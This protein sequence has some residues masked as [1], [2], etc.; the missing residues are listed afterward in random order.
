MRVATKVTFG[1]GLLLG[2]L[3]AVLVYHTSLVG[4]MASTG[5][6][7]ASAQFRVATLAIEQSRTAA[8]LEESLKKYA[9]TA[10]PAYAERARELGAAFD[11]RLEELGALSLSHREEKE[12]MALRRLWK[13]G[14]RTDSGAAV[15]WAPRPGSPDDDIVAAARLD[16]LSR[17]R[18]QAQAVLEAARTSIT[19][20]VEGSLRRS[21]R[22]ERIAR[23]VMA[24]AVGLAVIAVVITVRSI[25][26]PLRRLTEGTRAVAQGQFWYQLDETRGDEF[27]ELARDF[28]TMVRRLDELDRMKEGFLAHVSH[29]LRTPLV[30]I[31]ETTTLLLE[32]ETG[33]LNEQQRRLLELDRDSAQRLAAMIANLL[34]A[35]RMEHGAAFL[36]VSSH[37]LS[38][39]VRQSVAQLEA[40]ASE[41]NV[42][43]DAL[44]PPAA[45]I[46]RCD[47]DRMLQVVSNL[48]ENAI[49][50]SPP[51]STIRVR[52]EVEPPE[53]RASGAGS[54]HAEEPADEGR[55]VILAVADVGPGVLDVH[56]ERVF[57]KF[58]RIP[59]GRYLQGR[60]LGLGL[61]ICREIVEAHG[62]R[63]W[64]E[65]NPGGGS[66]FSLYIP[67]DG[68][69][70]LPQTCD[71]GT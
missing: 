38:L 58:Y 36:D 63:I 45:A 55:E 71:E 64:V 61:A 27:S 30:T 7:L 66:V 3:L 24:M 46:I 13:E 32:E 69:T 62:G 33:P 60:G 43:I 28:N 14:G 47:R 44:L 9:V 56:K 68:P 10:D 50:V 51:D 17:V 49:T 40:R 2:L 34:E 4:R 8:K 22:A 37:D 57:E 70:N 31:E 23:G 25:K 39:V 67:A 65:D 16:E 48:V 26:E 1:T 18:D 41:R 12:V 35:V 5:L 19:H 52:L 11:A 21:R 29:E 15:G 42:R 59:R 54:T 53:P 20:Q 6:R